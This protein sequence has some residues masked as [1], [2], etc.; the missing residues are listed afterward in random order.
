M[1]VVN[2]SSYRNFTS[3]INS[4]HD[5]LNK[6]MNKVSSGKA[7]ESAADNPLAYY[8]GQ[9]IDSQYQDI[10]SKISLT[11]D[12]KNRLYQQ[13]LGARS[14]QSSLSEAKTKIEYIRS[15]SNNGNM[16]TV[17]TVREALLQK[18]QSMVNDLNGQYQNFYIFG[19]NDISTAPFKLSSDGTTLTFTHTFSGDSAPTEMTMTL[20]K[21]SDGSYQYIY[22]DPAVTNPSDPR[23]SDGTLKNMV[24]AM[25]E[26]GRIDIG[27]GSIS[28]KN[29]LL[30]TCTGGLN[31]LTGL[32][33][34]AINT[35]SDA[36]AITE[37]KKRMNSS[38]VGLIGQA[39]KALDDYMAGGGK[40]EFSS[41]LGRVMDNMTD[42]EHY[43][44]TVYSDLGNKYSLLETTESKLGI[45]KDNLTEQYKDKLGADP[46]EAIM[47][48]YN[49]QYSY[50]ATQRIGSQLMQSSLFDFIK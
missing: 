49:Y 34:D 5:K 21:Q 3:S 27:Y 6:S 1:R 12:V 10:L 37:I 47:E 19:G 41:S 28:D 42:T 44:S 50:S 39:V 43:V 16:Q 48:M 33:S 30:D 23:S 14:I 20:E 46:Y 7:Y 32:T 15:D 35:M 36:Q 17:G 18:Q 38:P 45:M 40:D 31:L 29:T 25:R 22:G 11:T 13:E 2:S 4:V 26:Q 8:E 9:K 24:K